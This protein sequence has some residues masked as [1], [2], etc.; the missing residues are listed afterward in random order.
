MTLIEVFQNFIWV[1]ILSTIIGLILGFVATIVTKKVKVYTLNRRNKLANEP[2]IS[3]EWNA[4]FSEEKELQ[5][6]N[7]KIEQQGRV[8]VGTFKTLKKEYKFNGIFKNHIL[9][10]QYESTDSRKDERGSIVLRWI[11]EDLLSGYC[12]F[13]FKDKQVYNSAYVLTSSKSHCADKGTYSFCNSC[14]GKFDC[15]CNCE[16]IDMPILLPFEAKRLQISQRRTIDKFAKKLSEHLYQMRRADNDEKKGCIFFQNNRCSIYNERPLDCRLFPF[17]FK[18]KD[19]EYWIVYYNN[20]CNAI[21]TDKTEL[22]TCAHNMRPLLEI[23]MPYFSECSKEIFSKRLKEQ[24]CIYLF[25]LSKI[26]EDK[27]LNIKI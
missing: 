20:V 3:G 23:I 26:S 7:V 18:E 2:N 15:C 21:P 24:E 4:L 8:I 16:N 13:V 10:G 27:N 1:P 25:P 19:G 5:V 14:V 22:E 11:N 17:D 6:E 12:T 9:M